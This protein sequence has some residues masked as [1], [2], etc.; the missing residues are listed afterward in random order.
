MSNTWC[1]EKNEPWKNPLSYGASS[2]EEEDK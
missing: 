1:I 2:D